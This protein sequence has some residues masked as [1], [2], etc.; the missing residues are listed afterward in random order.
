MRKLVAVAAVVMT[1]TVVA[2]T[3]SASPPTTTAAA[4]NTTTWWVD[5]TWISPLAGWVLGE[6][7]AGCST[8][9]II[10]YTDDGGR[11]WTM[12]PTP[13]GRTLL[14]GG[15]T[16][17][18]QNSGGCVTHLVFVNRDDGYLFGPDLFTTT[19]GGRTWNRQRGKPTVALA[20]VAPG[21]VWRLTYDE[22]GCPGPCGLTLQQQRTGT[23]SW[24]TV[25]A[26]FDG[27]GTGL[28]PQIVSTDSARVLIAFYGNI[29]GGVS[30]HAT[31]FVAAN[32]GRSWSKRVDPC[33]WNRTNEVDAYDASA[34]PEGT[35]VVEC[36]AK[37]ISNQAFVM[38]SHNGGK[39]FGPRRPIPPLFANMV[40]VASAN[41]IVAATGEAGG[42][43][44]FTYTLER[45][46]NGGLS[47]RTVV[48]D[49]ET[50][51]SSTPGESYLGF[52]SPT[53]G[54]WIGF[55]NKLWTT[56]DGGEHWTASNV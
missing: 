6:G 22:D 30:S 8:C 11:T 5:S 32:L 21:V 47:W 48:R 24:V 39:T 1:L 36:L 56:T 25:R 41:T 45:S 18:C 23:T 16:Y 27:S 26:P 10:K 54:H 28:V 31:F 50:L 17:T 12:V 20:T 37:G 14:S 29:A 40:A 42:S 53:V 19:N 38:V 7:K 34:I 44:P 43:G 13:A 33:G 49:P 52:V 4:S 9:V 3:S 55:G 51:T 35:V 2:G 46:T 15:S